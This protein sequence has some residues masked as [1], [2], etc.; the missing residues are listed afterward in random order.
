MK[1]PGARVARFTGVAA[2]GYYHTGAGDANWYVFVDGAQRAG[3]R[4][5][6]NQFARV[7]IELPAAARFLTL[8]TSSNGTMNTDWTFFGNPRVLLEQDGDAQ[9][10]DLADIV[11]GGDGTGNGNSVG[12]DPWSGRVLDDQGAATS[13]RINQV[14][15]VSQRPLI[16][17]VF[18]PHGSGDGKREIP[19]S[20]SGLVVKGIS[21]GSGTTHAHIW[22]GHNQGVSGLKPIDVTRH[23]G[24]LVDLCLVLLNSAE[25]LYV[26]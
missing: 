13:G 21:A 24:A 10:F 4:L 25:F 19:V 17:A 12:L 11:G 15:P 2:L 18:V 14:Y 7:E 16:D 22:N 3:G 1:L 26:D 6:S 20:T 5:R 23:N 9:A 8:V